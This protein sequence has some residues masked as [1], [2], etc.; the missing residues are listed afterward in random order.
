[1][2]NKHLAGRITGL[3]RKQKNARFAKKIGAID[4]VGSSLRIV[5]DADLVVLATPVDKI[6]DIASKISKELKKTCI[7]IDVGSTKEKIVSKLTPLIPNFLGCHP[8]A[9]SEKKG[10]VNFNAGIFK[11]SIC[12]LTPTAKTNRRVL[13]K[14]KLLWKKLGVKVIVLSPEKHDQVLAATSHLPHVVAFSLIASIPDRFLSLSSSGLRDITRISGS[15][16]YL[17]SQI[18][19]SNR[20][21]LLSAVSSFQIKLSA[22]KS[23]LKNKNSKLLIKILAAAKKKREKLG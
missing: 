11:G 23:A 17:W 3:S 12:M 8:L 21:N 7:V 13:K 4:C 19:L 6:I 1:L 15:D 2:K 20:S 14:I 9:G 5:S 16:A 22:L 18:F 10:I